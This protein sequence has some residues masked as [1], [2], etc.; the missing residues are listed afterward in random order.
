MVTRVIIDEEKC[1]GCTLCVRA[2]PEVFKME[3]DKAVLL[4]NTVPPGAEDSC[5]DAV[6]QC[7]VEA[8]TIQQ[9]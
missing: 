7:P 8:I 3:G 6:Q 2:C 9:H 5:K 1:I 4:A